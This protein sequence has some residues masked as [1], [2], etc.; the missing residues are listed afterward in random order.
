M[1]IAIEEK[2]V[3]GLKVNLKRLMKMIKKVI[4]RFDVTQ[5]SNTTRKQVEN[6]DLSVI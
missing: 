4:I 5:F 1:R 6:L 3:N 2:S